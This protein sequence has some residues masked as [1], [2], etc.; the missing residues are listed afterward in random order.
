MFTRRGLAIFGL[1]GA[2][3][4]T[5]MTTTPSQAHA[6]LLVAS[7]GISQTLTSMPDRVTLTFDDSLIDLTGGNQ[8]LVSDSKGVQFQAGQATL[9]GA[10]LA[11]ALKPNLADGKYQVT[12]KV[13]SNDGHPVSS[14]YFFY[15][16]LAKSTASSVHKTIVCVRGTSVRKVTS[17]NPKCPPGFRKK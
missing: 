3:S 17:P 10:Q 9:T 7:P 11:V 6:Q 13:I 8:I 4:L 14:T 12:Y 2:M 5:F 16:N 1:L 15:L